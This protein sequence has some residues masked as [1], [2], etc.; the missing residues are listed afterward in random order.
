MSTV[1]AGWRG[2]SIVTDGLIIN[3]DANSGTSYSPYTSGVT[4]KDLSNN[5]NN[6]TLVNGPI[7]T[8]AN[9]GGIVFDGVDDRAN[10]SISL[11]FNS[12]GFTHECVF[13]LTS[14]PSTW[15]DYRNLFG[16]N[17]SSLSTFYG[18]LIERD[19]RGI[20]LDIPDTVNT[21]YGYTTSYA[22]VTGS[23]Y[24]FA[25]TWLNGLFTA[26]MNGALIGSSNVGS[27]T[28]KATT[29]L[30]LGY[31]AFSPKYFYGNHFIDRIYNRVLTA[32]EIQ[33][34]FNG[35]RARFGL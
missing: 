2:P 35:S 13:N 20:R 33:Q 12:R 25:W 3:L 15:P 21:R 29:Q 24:H 18:I 22:P 5:G 10:I 23:N 32:Q 6:A 9:G 1:N 11:D 27:Y 4:W 31:A 30:I 17:A 8:T 26:Y 34:N 19:S 28:A 7:Y 16:F 14:N